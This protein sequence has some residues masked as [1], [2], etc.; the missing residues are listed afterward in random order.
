MFAEG[1]LASELFGHEAGA[2]TGAAGRRRGVFEQA[3]GGTLFL[4]E[5]GELSA[6][7]AGD[8][9]ARAPGAG[10]C[11]GWAARRRSSVDVRVLAATHRDLAA[12]VEQ[13]TF[14]EDLYYRLRGAIARGAAAARAGG[15]DRAA[16]RRV[17]RRRLQSRRKG[18][19]AAR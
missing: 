15:D 10:R 13:G 1:V 14:R 12:M 11:G 2:F 7:G 6:A 4:D 17:P 19:A 16:R 18:A 8:A 3:H 9:A 5:I